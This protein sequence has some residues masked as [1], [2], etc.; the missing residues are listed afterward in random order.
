[1]LR[2]GTPQLFQAWKGLNLF[3]RSQYNFHCGAS[4]CNKVWVGLWGHYIVLLALSYMFKKKLQIC[5][6][7]LIWLQMEK[8]RTH[9][10]L[11]LKKLKRK[12]CSYF[13][14]LLPIEWDMANMLFLKFCVKWGKKCAVSEMI[15]LLEINTSVLFQ[16]IEIFIY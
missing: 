2:L 9:L 4:R 15:I 8:L 10:F 12:K 5:I 6:I 11:Q 16:S 7:S 14:D 3:N 1:M 13:H